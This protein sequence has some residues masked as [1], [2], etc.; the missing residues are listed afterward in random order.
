YDKSG[1]TEDTPNFRSRPDY[2]SFKRFDFDPFDTYTFTS[3]SGGQ[4]YH[5]NFNAPNTYHKMTITARA[6]ENNVIPASHSRPYLILF[7]G[8]LCFACL[9]METYWQKIVTDLEPLGVGFATIHSQH[10]SKL[11]R[12]LSVQTLPYIMSLVEGEPRAYREPQ[13]SLPNIVE[14]I[15]RSLPKDLVQEVTDSNYEQFL[16]GWHDNRVRTLFVTEESNIRL[17]Y[18]LIAYEF[19]ERI[20][21]AHV[22]G[23]EAS[24][25]IL[26]RYRVDPKMNSMLIFNEDIT[27]TT[28][29]LSVFELKPQLMRDVLE[30]NKFLLLPRLAS[31]AMFDQLCPTESV[32]SRRRLCV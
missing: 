8:D 27:R 26:T 28:A 31:Q 29:T 24:R 16:N 21:F 3:G 4:Q 12:K 2:S 23:N 10:E 1:V 30:S 17:R 6:Y 22:T 11:A 18:Q 7:Y 9:Q 13:I 20:A 25:Q 19:R 14:F 32:R 15:R 5:F